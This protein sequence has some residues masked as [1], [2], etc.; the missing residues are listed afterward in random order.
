ME[1]LQGYELNNKNL[2]RF[3]EIT[4]KM[5]EKKFVYDEIKGHPTKYELIKHIPGWETLD[6]NHSSIKPLFD[7]FV[8]KRSYEPGS[9]EFLLPET[10]NMLPGWNVAN[11]TKSEDM[12]GHYDILVTS[13]KYNIIGTIQVY[14]GNDFDYLMQKMKNE[15]LSQIEKTGKRSVYIQSVFDGDFAHKDERAYKWID[16]DGS[17][18]ATVFFQTPYGLDIN[19]AKQIEKK[20]LLPSMGNKFTFDF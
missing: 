9:A 7:K 11:S 5:M 19:T 16:Y 20:I 12:N 13:F 4:H 8:M 10:I 2:M 3:K 14:S 6:I 1:K 17:V 18:K 15:M